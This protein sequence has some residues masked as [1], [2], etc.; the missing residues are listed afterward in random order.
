MIL[1]DKLCR[2]LYPEGSE[3]R[4]PPSSLSLL[5]PFHLHAQVPFLSFPLGI[6]FQGLPPHTSVKVSNVCDK[7][8]FQ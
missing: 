4:S 8:H 6:R 7:P 1:F 2:I 5:L 3:P